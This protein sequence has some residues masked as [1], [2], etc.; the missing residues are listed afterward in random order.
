[1]KTKSLFFLALLLAPA[2]K[3][4]AQAPDCQFT[5]QASATGVQAPSIS[6]R[7]TTSGGS[8]GCSAW[9]FKYYTNNSSATSIELDGAADLAGAPTGAY[10]ALTVSAASGSGANPALGTAEGGAVLCCDYYPW[11][12][13]NVNTLTGTGAKI[14]VRAYG[15]KNNSAVNGGGGGGSGISACSTSPPTTGLA[16][17]VCYDTSG[18]LWKCNNGSSACTLTAQ[19]VAQGG[20][21]TFVALSGDATSTATGG[22][23]SVIGLNNTLLSGLANGLLTNT[24]GTGIPTITAKPT[25]A[26][27]GAGQANTFTTGLQNFSAATGFEIPTGAGLV[28]TAN[29]ML[30]YDSTAGLPHIWFSGADHTFGTSAF[31]SAFTALSGDATSTST[32]GATTVTGTNGGAIPKVGGVAGLNTSG[33]FIQANANVMHFP[34]YGAAGG[35]AQAQT[36]TLTPTVTLNPHYTAFCF[37]PVAANTG[38]APTLTLSGDAAKPIVGPGGAALIANDLL[39]TADACVIYD[40]TSFELQNPQTLATGN[41]CLLTGCT[42]TGNLLFTDATYDIGASGATRPRNGYFSGSVTAPGG[43]SGGSSFSAS[44]GESSTPSAPSA[45]TLNFNSGNH[46]PQ[47]TKAGNSTIDATTVVPLASRTAHYFATYIDNTGTQNTA[48]IAATDLPATNLPTPGTSVTVA[49]PHGYAICTGTCTV[50][51]PAPT[52]AGDDFCI[53]NDVGV[54]TAITISGQTGVYFSNVATSAYG[55]VS[56]SFTATAAGGNKVCMVAR[57]TTHW[58]VLSYTGVWTAN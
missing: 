48:L 21:G 27:V 3:L 9:I 34:L 7:F 37:T 22:A 19:W 14:T 47:F 6:N 32:G 8:P 43:F 18:V 20:S 28:A 52:A 17:A 38:G 10:T 57:D 13:F 25:G 30:G 36:L 55:A 31:A 40:G 39:A 49:L 56:G 51:L 41:F 2:W 35:I 29:L 54:G 45:D 5:F 53:W 44:G 50:T 24:T 23:T 58:I 11:L 42:M 16:N 15:Y 12:R 46:I 4:A 1:M 33:Q 26:L